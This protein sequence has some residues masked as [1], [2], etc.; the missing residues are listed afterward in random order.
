MLLVLEV[1]EPLN[2]AS[3][4]EIVGPTPTKKWSVRRKTNGA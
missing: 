1:L 3:E 2:A 4:R